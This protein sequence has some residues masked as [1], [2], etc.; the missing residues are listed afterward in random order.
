MPQAGAPPNLFHYNSNYEEKDNGELPH[1]APRTA[2][3]IVSTIYKF[4]LLLKLNLPP[5]STKQGFT[6]I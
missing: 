6:I 4:L 1:G 5:V 3:A 2:Q